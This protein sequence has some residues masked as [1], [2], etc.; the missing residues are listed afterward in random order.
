MNDHTS[1]DAVCPNC[2]H[3]HHLPGTECATPVNHGPNRWHLCLCLARPGAALSCPPQM[4]CQ[5]GTLGY[6]DVWYLQHGHTLLG[7]DGE[8]AP[9]VF[10]SGVA[11]V[12]FPSGPD[13]AAA[14]SAVRPPATD[15]TEQVAEALASLQGTVHHLP[16]ATRQAVI[17]ALVPVLPEPA[18][19]AAV[20]REAADVVLEENSRCPAVGSCQ[21]CE[22]RSRS[23]AELR[24]LTAEP[25]AAGP[26]QT[27]DTLP[28]WLYQRFMPGGEGWANL[29]ADQ[30]SYWEHQARA[31]RRAVERGGFK[32]AAAPGRADDDYE[33]TTGHRITCLAVA[34][35]DSDPDCPA[36]NPPFGTPDCTC[37]PFT[38][39]DGK[40]R[41]CG[42]TD[43]VDMISGWE[44]GRDCPHHAPAVGG[45]Q[46][47]SRTARF[48]DALTHSGPG[49]DLNPPTNGGAQ[50]QEDQA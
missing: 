49:Y 4:T 24:R 31:V 37:I 20:L 12:G 28:A 18:D 1:P 33:A 48:L 46:Q 27:D 29:D 9:G 13:I 26:D 17:D 42:P 7:E 19:R 25:A 45:A 2:S 35:G 39:Q 23:A 15:R 6:A 3:P 38:R 14:V 40:P 47:R 32:P 34:G 8:I 5:G 22:T 16:P 41:Y 11:S 43:T 36:C 21:P 10:V 30:R 44:I 50:Q